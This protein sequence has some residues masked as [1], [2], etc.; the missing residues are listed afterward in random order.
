ML[1]G[2]RFSD[3]DNTSSV[4]KKLTD[5]S[6]EDFKNRYEQWLKRWDHS[7]ILEGD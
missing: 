4:K 7:K 3:D 5:I 6:V 2:K 1:K